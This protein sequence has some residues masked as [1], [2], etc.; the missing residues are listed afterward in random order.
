MAYVTR[1]KQQTFFWLDLVWLTSSWNERGPTRRY[2]NAT[3]HC[4]LY[5]A[6]HCW[7]VWTFMVVRFRDS[8]LIGIQTEIACEEIWTYARILGRL[9]LEFQIIAWWSGYEGMGWLMQ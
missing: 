5:K 4:R 2:Y 1:R 6:P 3:F 8:Y 9:F 7:T